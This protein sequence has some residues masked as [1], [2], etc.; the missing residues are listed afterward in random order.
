MALITNSNKKTAIFFQFLMAL[1]HHANSKFPLPPRARV[2]TDPVHDFHEHVV[3][4]NTSRLSGCQHARGELASFPGTTRTCTHALHQATAL[5]DPPTAPAPPNSISITPPRA[6]NWTPLNDFKVL[7]STSTTALE[8]PFTGSC[9]SGFTRDK[10]RASTSGN[11][12][13]TL[14]I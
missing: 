5:L 2:M 13:N 14:L 11:V 10:W 1:L 6:H 12:M 4:I 3:T 8:Q 9:T 7:V